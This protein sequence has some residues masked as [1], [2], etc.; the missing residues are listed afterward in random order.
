MELLVEKPAVERLSSSEQYEGR[1]A[2]VPLDV[3]DGC[4]YLSSNETRGWY[5]TL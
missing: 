5:D 4:W 3:F 1:I 2:T